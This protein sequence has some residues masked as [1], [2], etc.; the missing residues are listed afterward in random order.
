MMKEETNTTFAKYVANI[1]MEKIK[2]ALIET[3]DPIKEI[4]QSNG[5]YDV[6]NFT[7]KFRQ[8]VGVTPGQFRTI[9]R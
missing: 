1:R 7:R 2:Q 4:I 8:V 3:D 9:H 5:Y 6:S